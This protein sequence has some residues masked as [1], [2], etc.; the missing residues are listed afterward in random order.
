MGDKNAR[1]EFFFSVS[2]SR[3][4]R[5]RAAAAPLLDLLDPDGEVPC[6]ACGKQ[7]IWTCQLGE[8]CLRWV[9]RRLSRSSIL[10]QNHR[11]REGAV[12][13]A[14]KWGRDAFA[15][16]RTEEGGCARL[17]ALP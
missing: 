9:D 14:R 1:G 16:V 11:H 17:L 8:V 12:L 13:L 10:Y 4:V 2:L 7:R 15:V 5:M 3:S 6:D